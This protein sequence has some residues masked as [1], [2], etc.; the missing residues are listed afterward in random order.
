MFDATG[1]EMFEQFPAPT[2]VVDGDVRI[3][4]MNRAARELRGGDA[5][6]AL[7]A[8]PGDVLGCVH[9]RGP[10]GCGREA[11]CGECVLRSSVQAALAGD[12]VRRARSFHRVRRGGGEVDVCAL[13]SASRVGESGGVVLTLEDVSDVELKHEVIRAEAALGAALDRAAMLARFPEENP[14]PVLRLAGD[15]TLLYANGA[16]LSALGDLRLE[17]SRPVPPEIAA[18]A[19]RALAERTRVRADV[20]SGGRV[21]SLSLCPVGTEVN[22]YGDDVTDRQRAHEEL[23][24]EKERLAVTLRSI[25]DGV[26]VTDAAGRVTMLNGVAEDLTGWRGPDGVG[27]DVEDVFRIVQ[28]GTHQRVPSPVARALREGIVAGLANHTALIARDGAERPIADSAAPI[29]DASGRVLGAVL[30]FRDQTKERLAEEALRQSEARIRLKLDSILSPEGELGRLRLA[31]ILDTEAVQGLMN[32]LHRASGIPLGVIDTDGKVLVGAGWQEVC[33]RFHRVHPETCRHCIE[34]DTRLSAGARPGEIK[35]YK[36]RNSMWDAAT[37]IVVDGQ[38]LGNVFAG[39][40][41]FDDETPDHELFRAQA[42]RYGFDIGAYLAALERVPRVPRDRVNAG[43]AFLLGFAGMLSRL[44]FGNMKLA[45]SLAEREALTRSLRAKKEQLEEADRKKDEFLGMLSHEL[46]NPLAPIRNSIHIL[47]QAVPGSE[48]AARAQRVIARQT[49]HLT[50]L[51]DDLLDVTRIARGKI[52]LRR[53]RAGLRTLVLHAGDDF[54]A[55]MEERGITFEVAV[56]AAEAWADVDAA[57]ITQVVG[58]LLHN[59][60]KFSA[61]GD[62]V[63]LTLVAGPQRAEIVVKDSGSGI[64]PALLPSVF[65][66]FV[67]GEHTLARSSGGLGLGL[68]LVKGITELHGGAARAESGGAGQGARFTVELPLSP[69]PAASDGA[70][71][72]AAVDRAP[73]PR[74]VLVIDDNRDAAQSLAEIVEMLGHEA[75][76]AFDGPSAI[77]KATATTPDV[78]ICDIGLPGMSGHEVARAIRAARGEGVR[79][80][81]VSGYAQPDDVSR[82]LA[83]GFDGHVAKP[84]DMAQIERLLS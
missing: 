48:Q 83:A 58:N 59:A 75:D 63:S 21:F 56:P 40:F 84:A 74:R 29:R 77:A 13:V 24:S 57:R 60:A 37:P 26:I 62:H 73:E 44:T 22:V 16:A 17:L 9:A 82:A 78:V 61:R 65:E 38:H 2:F 4:S 27:A 67:Q 1:Q 71:A 7:P 11:A 42:E 68:A 32:E 28:E 76:V 23:A 47:Q 41:F 50:R 34:S 52:E 54:R 64:D 12:A 43:M 69:E 72:A 80:F 31:D 39:Q 81:A 19:R 66:A 45:R 10:G 35:L 36:C 79:L 70:A 53:R 30:V 3:V 51:V 46:R 49:D 33:T 25:G 5:G 18:P 55:V 15:L 14:D 8:L 20:S 6:P